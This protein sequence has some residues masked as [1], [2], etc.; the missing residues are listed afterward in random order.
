M[1]I[2]ACWLVV[3]S[4]KGACVV[5]QPTPSTSG[6]WLPAH[7]SLSKKK[8]PV[9]MLLSLPSCFGGW[10][11]YVCRLDLPTHAAL[12]INKKEEG[13]SAVDVKWVCDTCVKQQTSYMCY[14]RSSLFLF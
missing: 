5:D 7:S 3:T 4:K 8:K 6:R 12:T 9:Q 2:A 10:F 14:V 11:N 1:P 13:S